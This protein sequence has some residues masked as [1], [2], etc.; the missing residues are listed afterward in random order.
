[1]RS[2]NE[3]SGLEMA[4]ALAIRVGRILEA[5]RREFTTYAGVETSL[6]AKHKGVVV[7]N[8]IQFPDKTIEAAYGKDLE[9]ADSV[10]VDLPGEKITEADINT[11]AKVKPSVLTDI[12]WLIAS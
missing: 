3:F 12:S 11:L 7:G 1:M 10:E 5:A 8:T 2:L 4:P 9:E 6:I